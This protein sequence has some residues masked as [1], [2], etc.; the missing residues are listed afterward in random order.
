MRVRHKIPSVFS[1][2]MVD[3]LCCALGCV[4]LLWLL[5]AKQ[6]EDDV[7]ALREQAVSER[8]E[9][10][11]MLASAR[12]AAEALDQRVRRL[13]VDRDRAVALEA[14][15]AARIAEMEKTRDLL[16]A[17]L[18]GAQLRAG[19][20]SG[21]LKASLARVDKLQTELAA[22]AAALESERKK[23]TATDKVLAAAEAGLKQTRS[24]L[25][26]EKDRHAAA[27]RQLSELNRDV[28]ARK[29]ELAGLTK[30]LSEAEAARKKLEGTLAVRDKDFAAVKREAGERLDAAAAREQALQ[31]QLRDRDAAVHNATRAF[32][33]LKAE[34]AALRAVEGGRFAGITL[35]GKRVIFLVDMSGSMKQVDAKTPA[36]EKWQEVANTV[37]RLMRSLPDLEKYQILCFSTRL[38]YPLG[39]EG[40]WRDFDPT[41]SPQQAV[42]ALTAIEPRSGTNMS[43]ALEATF[44][45]RADK[46]DTV[47]LLSDGLPNHGEGITDDKAEL[48]ELERGLLLGRY[49]RRKLKEQWNKPI[50]NERVKINTIGFFFESPDLGSF[51]WALARENDGNFVGMSRP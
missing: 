20:L 39:D 43:L 33:K 5:G 4:I 10:A 6:T 48:S 35:S 47:Y 8:E 41:K 22:G 24:D 27:Q 15:L 45:Y 11:K 2:S 34:A 26:R 42:K 30:S 13:L 37:G 38:L 32:E 1:L 49:V 50:R 31:A 51:L 29:R 16:A 9:S 21:R 19:D 23:A 44:K 40:K 7:G 18:K 3:V 17:D 46:L 28:E 25:D 12:D 36:P 14:R